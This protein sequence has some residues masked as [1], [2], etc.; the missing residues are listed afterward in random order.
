MNSQLDRVGVFA[1]D[2]AI[3]QFDLNLQIRIFH[4]LDPTSLAQI[5][6]TSNRPQV[7]FKRWPVILI[8]NNVAG[9]AELVRECAHSSLDFAFEAIMCGIQAKPLQVRPLTR[10]NRQATW[11]THSAVVSASKAIALS[12]V[13]SDATA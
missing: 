9:T 7:E 13:F 12:L 11:T 10:A 3:E 8:P 6:R 1:R 4:T 5:E 2:V